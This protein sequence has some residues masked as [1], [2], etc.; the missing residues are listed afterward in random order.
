MEELKGLVS[1]AQELQRNVERLRAAG[2]PN[3]IVANIIGLKK[4]T[5]FISGLDTHEVTALRDLFGPNGMII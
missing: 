2:G 5:P 1:S 4:A 3:G